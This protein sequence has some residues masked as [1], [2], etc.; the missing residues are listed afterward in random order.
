MEIK[1][2][3]KLAKEAQIQTELYVDEISN[4]DRINPKQWKEKRTAESRKREKERYDKEMVDWK[5]KCKKA[6]E[7]QKWW[8]CKE[9]MPEKPSWVYFDIHLRD[10]FLSRFYLCGKGIKSAEGDISIWYEPL[11]QRILEGLISAQKTHQFKRFE[12][13]RI[14]PIEDSPM[15]MVGFSCW[16]DEWGYYE[17]ASNLENQINR[18]IYK[19]CEWNSEGIIKKD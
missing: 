5:E 8:V 11:S 4:Y 17:D 18:F 12:I 1:E 19:I 7:E 10:Y 9:K 2:L 16:L 3:K 15:I 6:K 13:W 14:K